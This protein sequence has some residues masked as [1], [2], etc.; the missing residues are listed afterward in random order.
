MLGFKGNA[1]YN[2]EGENKEAD[3]QK[4]SA[5]RDQKV[6]ALLP[7][8]KVCLLYAY[9]VEDIT[10]PAKTWT[11]SKAEIIVEPAGLMVLTCLGMSPS[12]CS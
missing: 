7:Y 3:K 4:C 11:R 8:E 5:R 12:G 10:A 1:V 9:V 6:V 2:R